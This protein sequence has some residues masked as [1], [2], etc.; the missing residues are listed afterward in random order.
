[1]SGME[2]L[3]ICGSRRPWFS[4]IRPLNTTSNAADAQVDFFGQDAA[5]LQ[6]TIGEETSS[7]FQVSL[8]PKGVIRLIT[9]GEG[10]GLGWAAV[11]MDQPLNGSGIFQIFEA[12]SQLAGARPVAAGALVTEVGVSATPLYNQLDLIVNTLGNL[13]TGVAL[14]L[15]LIYESD[16]PGSEVRVTANLRRKEGSIVANRSLFVPNGGHRSLFVTEIFPD[17]PDST[18]IHEFE[19]SMTLSSSALMAP[20]ALSS[21]GAKL[22]SNPVLRT[23]LNT[24]SPVS[25]VTPFQNLTGTAPGFHWLLHQNDGDLALEKVKIFAPELGLDTDAI[26]LG[27]AL[28]EGYMAL[29]NNTR[30]FEFRVGGKGSIEFDALI[31]KSDG[32][33]VQGTG[34]MTGTPQGGLEVELTLLGKEP[35]TEVGDDADQEFFFKPGIILAPTSP[36]TV[37]ITT[38]FTSVS[39]RP[40]QDA[41]VI[42]KT[43]QELTFVDPDAQRPNLEYVSPTFPQPSDEIFL[44]GTNFGEGPTVSFPGPEG[45]RII[46]EASREEGGSLRAVVPA[47][48]VD[49]EIM[50]DNGSGEGNPYRLKVV[51]GPTHQFTVGAN[52]N[53]I[54]QDDPIQDFELVFEQGPVEFFMEQALAEIYN[55]DLDFETLE[56]DSVVGK[57][58]ERVRRSSEEFDLKIT[59][60]SAERLVLQAVDSNSD[61]AERTVTVGKIED[62]EG[63]TIGLVFHYRPDELYEDPVMLEAG[64]DHEI[65]LSFTDLPVL[66]PDPIG[67]TSSL[68]FMIS[69]TTDGTETKRRSIDL[70][71]LDVP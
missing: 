1:M 36:G 10:G 30:T 33:L 16:E 6:V 46:T 19:G 23:G 66:W 8:Q 38:E 4:L 64:Y 42:R 63:S 58:V 24:F 50:V 17:L 15:P 61:S 32:V 20:L 47:E 68:A 70:S 43:T 31:T 41:P 69:T 11:T 21:A 40:D 49:G 44:A 2:S 37:T 9:S 22:T 35:F 28:A 67:R 55:L 14:A 57:G 65:R 60:A 54:Q 51:F 18:N 7:S 56:V 71:V 26:G 39:S 52:G 5:P 59:E 13:N 12:D 29:G 45:E 3:G 25:E 62:D 48:A 27:D 53:T 34:I